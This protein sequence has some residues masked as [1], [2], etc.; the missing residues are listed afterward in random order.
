MMRRRNL[1]TRKV[2]LAALIG[3]LLSVGAAY[4]QGSNE[5]PV[6]NS[7]VK[8]AWA[9]QFQINN[10]FDLNSF[11][12]STFSLKKQTSPGA[13]WRLGLSLALSFSDSDRMQSS[14]G[15]ESPSESDANSQTIDV[16]LQRVFYPN[17]GSRVNLYYGLGPR[18]YYRHTW[19]KQLRDMTDSTSTETINKLNNWEVGVAGVLGVEWFVTK[20]ISLLGE[21]GSSLMYS[22]DKVRGEQTLVRPDGTRVNATETKTNE[23]SFGASAVKLG[24]SVYF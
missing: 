19:A 16:T 22:H 11:N 14:G 13:A 5:P 4:S 3:I 6:K 24:L 18:G 15:L 23:V 17:P 20:N 9:L 21:Y 1:S 10:D 8:G 2:M 12:G 7:L